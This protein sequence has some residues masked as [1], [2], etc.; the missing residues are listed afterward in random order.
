[1]NSL[2]Q[3]LNPPQGI[4]QMSQN[5]YL[6]QLIKTFKN[7]NNPQGFIRNYLQNNMN[8]PQIQN[9]YS[10]LKSGTRSPKEL[11]YSLAQ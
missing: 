7:S 10:L 6:Q 9:I 8:N 2:Y 1:M 11:F 4:T 3:E 5:N